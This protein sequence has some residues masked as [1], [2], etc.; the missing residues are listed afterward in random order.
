MMALHQIILTLLLLI[1]VD[2]GLC[3]GSLPASRGGSI[4]TL[5]LLPCHGLKKP[6]KNHPPTAACCP[7]RM[8]SPLDNGDMTKIKMLPCNDNCVK[9]AS[10]K[11]AGCPGRRAGAW[12]GSRPQAGPEGTAPC[13]KPLG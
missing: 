6:P 7:N 5:S 9:S 10:G 11:Q 8:F 2:A 4:G 12:R 13:S 1:V 3:Q